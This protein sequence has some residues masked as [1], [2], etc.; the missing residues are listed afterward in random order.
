[1]QRFSLN[2]KVAVVTGAGR[3]IGRAIA[4]G[5]A[6]AGADVV[7]AARTREEI[8]RAAAEIHAATGRRAVAIRADISRGEDA[9]TLLADSVAALGRLDVLVNNAGI[10]P[11]Y[12]R[13]ERLAEVA[14]RRVLDVNLTGTFLCCQAAAEYLAAGGRVINLSSVGA[15]VGLPRLAAY[16]AAKAGVEALTRVLALEWAERGI[17]VNAIGPA[18]IATDMTAGLRQNERLHQALVG[19]T[20][21][22]RLGEPDEVVGAAVFLASSASSYL[23]GQTIYVDGGWLAH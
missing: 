8:E 9:R 5:L 16:C 15:V 13:A 2:G 21:M 19:H 23:T 17:T 12:T 3:G 10:S 14:W 1:M 6:E 4:H 7:L 22:G 11:A 18:F 20:P